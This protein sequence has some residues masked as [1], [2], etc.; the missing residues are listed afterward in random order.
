MKLFEGRTEILRSKEKRTK[1]E[2]TGKEKTEN[3]AE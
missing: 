2:E 3:F 1:T